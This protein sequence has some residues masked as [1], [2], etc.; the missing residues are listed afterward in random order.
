MPE[1][2]EVETVVRGLQTIVGRR[3]VAVRITQGDFV[4]DPAALGAWLPGSR[5]ARIA[6]HGKYIVM[7]LEPGTPGQG[8]ASR[9]AADAQQTGTYF[10]VHLGMTGRLFACP[11]GERV[12]PHTHVYLELDDGRQVRYVDIRRFGRMTILAASEMEP[13]LER[14]GADPLA[15]PC[16]E[17]VER[18]HRR[19]ARIKALLLAQ[20]ALSGMGNIYADESLWRA[21]IHPARM[22]AKLKPAQLRSL[23]AAMRAVLGAAIELGGSSISDFLDT[24]GKPGRYQRRHRVYGREGKPCPRCG[25][26]IRRTVVAGRGTYFCPRC[27][28]P[29]SRS[30]QARHKLRPW[31]LG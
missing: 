3:F 16:T 20:N 19:R 25:A 11:P 23:W 6:R 10:I 29:P 15:I 28:R 9:A 5:I 26:R 22:A 12:A 4:D 21:R 7:T 1:L 14:L 24:E 8:A 27:Q 18:L 2:P 13:F 30:A 17:F 31:H